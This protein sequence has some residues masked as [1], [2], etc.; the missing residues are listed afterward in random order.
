M[1]AVLKD[2]AGNVVSRRESDD[3]SANDPNGPSNTNASA[4]PFP[5]AKPLR[6]ITDEM[7]HVQFPNWDT[8]LR[9]ENDANRRRFM[10][11]PFGNGVV[12]TAHYGSGIYSVLVL[13]GP[14][15]G[16]VWVTDPH[17]GDYVPAA[18]R[19]DLHD[20]LIKTE[21]S[22]SLHEIGFSFFDWYNHWLSAAAREIE[23]EYR[24]AT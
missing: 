11:I 10:A 2:N 18:M 5:L 23:R 13:N 4:R 16:Q 9:D 22:Y 14:F 1:A 8:R 21:N 24:S 3:V 7:W 15:R 12:K 20:S 17:M 6:S 19:T